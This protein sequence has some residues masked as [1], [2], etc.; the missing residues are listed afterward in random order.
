MS[1]TLTIEPE[2]V[3]EAESCAVR[4]GTTLDAMIRACLLVFVA[5]DGMAVGNARAGRRDA[6]PGAIKI[7]SMKDEVKLPD[8]FDKT[9]DSLDGEVAA[10]FMGDAS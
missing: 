3:K 4:N 1:Y 8:N 10:M 2:I 7:G 9:F 5:R 6:I